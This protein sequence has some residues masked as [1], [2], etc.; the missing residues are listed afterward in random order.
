VGRQLLLGRRLRAA[1]AD[2]TGAASGAAATGAGIRRAFSTDAA[3]CGGD[4]W[5]CVGCGGCVSVTD[6]PAAARTNTPPAPTLKLCEALPDAD[7][8]GAAPATLAAAVGTAV[9]AAAV[10]VAAAGARGDGASVAARAAAGAA[11]AVSGD[12]VA[13]AGGAATAAP[14]AA[15]APAWRRRAARLRLRLPAARARGTAAWT[16]ISSGSACNCAAGAPVCVDDG[17]C[18]GGAC[19][20]VGAVGCAASA[21]RSGGRGGGGGVCPPLTC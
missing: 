19:A 4:C 17:A 10:D 6:A 1:A 5:G 12:G 16:G 2:C 9:G 13:A 18:G 15:A 14:A 8:T 3:V 21:G 20:S 7:S 11:P